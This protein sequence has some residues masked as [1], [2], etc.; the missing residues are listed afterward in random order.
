MDQAESDILA[1]TRAGDSDA[2]TQL[3]QRHT[4]ALAADLRARIPDR[5]RAL[6]SIED[7]LHETFTDVFLSI[8]SFV[9]RGDGT[10]SARLRKLAQNNLLEAIQALEAEK[11]GGGKRPAF[12]KS[13]PGA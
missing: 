6:L 3:L 8:S 11:R 2:L 13:A 4:P 5:W 7:I 1:R 12:E 10:F 9:P